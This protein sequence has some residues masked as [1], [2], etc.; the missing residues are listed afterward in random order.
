MVQLLDALK[1]VSLTSLA[2][3]LTGCGISTASKLAELLSGATKFSAGVTRLTLDSNGIFGELWVDGDV[4]KAEKFVAD[5]DAFLAALKDSNILTLSLQKTGIGPLTLW[6]LATSLPTTL[7][8]I[9]VRQNPDID[10]ASVAALRAAAEETS[11]TIL[12]NDD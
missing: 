9:D 1:D 6:K 7:T 5:C 12:A 8:E 4:K 2:I 10:E 11:C 3:S